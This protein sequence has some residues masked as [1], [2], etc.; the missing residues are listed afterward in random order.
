MNEP[1]TVFNFWFELGKAIQPAIQ[2]ALVY[3]LAVAGGVLVQ[4]TRHRRRHTSIEQEFNIAARIAAQYEICRDRLGPSCMRAYNTKYHNGEE[5]D[6]GTPMR[7]KSRTYEALR[8]GVTP[9]RDN[10]KG[11]LTSE[12]P[13]ELKLV[14]DDGPS[15]TLIRDLKPTKFRALCEEGGGR[16]VARCAIRKYGKVVGFVGADF[17]GD[18]DTPPANINELCL[19]AER[20]GSIL[21]RG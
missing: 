19:L 1:Q 5:F 16:A 20:I 14:L 7:R 10:F 15:Y 4:W 12:L 6:D 21:S 13:D 2:A 18:C 3:G 9:Q 8:P 11:L 17:D